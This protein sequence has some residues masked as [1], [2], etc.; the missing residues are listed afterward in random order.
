MGCLSP[1]EKTPVIM[2]SLPRVNDCMVPIAE[3]SW[4]VAATEDAAPYWVS[5]P[6][7]T[8][9]G[10][11]QPGTVG[12]NVNEPPEVSLPLVSKFSVVGLPRAFLAASVAV[13]VQVSAAVLVNEKVI[14]W[15]LPSASYMV[16]EV[17][18]VVGGVTV[19]AAGRFPPTDAV[20]V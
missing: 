16:I 3:P 19:A 1:L 20:P 7:S 18:T 9:T 8:V 11:V 14:G 15:A 13:T 6:M 4:S 5:F 10:P 17:L 12:L 2:P